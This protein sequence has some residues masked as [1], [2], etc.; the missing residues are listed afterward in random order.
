MW[1]GL[2][3][4]SST[5]REPPRRSRASRLAGHERYAHPR[6]VD[7]PTAPII[8]VFL[9]AVAVHLALAE[10]DA[11]AE[12]AVRRGGNGVITYTD[13]LVANGYTETAGDTANRERYGR[14]A[15]TAPGGDGVEEDQPDMG[16]E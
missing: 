1:R 7:R 14:T 10:K 3:S 16:T 9:S 8:W 6:S 2:P 15:G 11:G 13:F 4:A 5:S 12:H